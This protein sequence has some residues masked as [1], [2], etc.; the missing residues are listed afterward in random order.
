ME[1]VLVT[2]QLIKL[3][4]RATGV[5]FRHHKGEEARGEIGLI[6]SL[7]GGLE[8]RTEIELPS[9]VY[10]YGRARCQAH[11]GADVSRCFEYISSAKYCDNWQAVCAV[12]KAGDRISLHWA[13][14][15][16]VHENL[17]AIGGGSDQLFLTVRR[18]TDKRCKYFKLHLSTAVTTPATTYPMIEVAA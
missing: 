6:Q 16:L 3:M 15:A 12:L 9:K 17:R 13:K 14:G 7:D 2:S 4:A 11:T 10:V 1:Q 18:G 5:T 8:T